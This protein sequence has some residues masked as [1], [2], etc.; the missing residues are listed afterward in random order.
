MDRLFRKKTSEKR[1]K[2]KKGK[3]E[4]PSKLGNAGIPDGNL[5]VAGP[6][7]SLDLDFRSSLMLPSLSQR[8]SVLMPSLSTAPEESLRALLASQRARSNGPALTMEE[9][10]ML[11]AELRGDE[12]GVDEREKKS[13]G[14]SSPGQISLFNHSSPF[15]TS[16]VSSPSLLTSSDDGGSA[17]PLH[18]ATNF[19][20]SPPPTSTSFSSFKTFG[21]GSSPEQP[22]ES[23]S[24]AKGMSY[25]I[26]G[27]INL[28]DGEYMRRAKKHASSKDLKASPSAKSEKTARENGAPSMISTEKANAYFKGHQ[29]RISHSPTRSEVTAT[30]TSSGPYGGPQSRP[31]PTVVTRQPEPNSPDS[32]SFPQR[33][34]RK[35]LLSNLS[36]AQ[37][38]RISMALEEI[39]GE[40]QRGSSLVRKDTLRKA[41][42]EEESRAD[43]EEVLASEDSQGALATLSE[44]EIDPSRRPDVLSEGESS[45][46]ATSSVF[47]FKT[48]PTNSTFTGSTIA[49]TTEPG[50]PSR[51]PPSPRS[52]NLRAVIDD[53][54][55]P[56]PKPIFTPTRTTPVK[57]HYSLSN[58]SSSSTP[59]QIPPNPAYVPGQPRPI[60]S[61]HHSVSSISSSR[62]GTPSGQSPLDALKNSSRSGTPRSQSPLDALRA[63]T[64]TTFSDVTSATPSP[65]QNYALDSAKTGSLMRSR[66]LQTSNPSRPVELDLVRRRAGTVVLGETVTPPRRLTSPHGARRGSENE[67]IA[68]EDEDVVEHEDNESTPE[69]RQV[70]SRHSVVVSSY[71]H[72]TATTVV[73]RA[74]VNEHLP[75]PGDHIERTVSA[76]GT[77]KT[78]EDTP[79]LS[80]RAS[81][82][83][84]D[85]DYAPES[86]DTQWIDV[87]GS[88][89]R[90]SLVI[91]NMEYAQD[92]PEG[93]LRKMSGLGAEELAILQGKLVAKAKS[94]REAMGLGDSPMIPATPNMPVSV[95]SAVQRSMSPAVMTPPTFSS[96]STSGSRAA[97]PHGT[98]G[99]STPPPHSADHILVKQP[100]PAVPS[101]PPPPAPASIASSRPLSLETKDALVASPAAPELTNNDL[102]TEKERDFRTRIA[103]A[104]ASLNR[105]PPEQ[106]VSLGRKN[107]KRGM[108]IVI[109]GPKLLSSTAKVPVVPLSPDHPHTIDP[110]MAK[111]LEK[112]SGSGSKMSQRWRKLMRKGPSIT[113]SEMFKQTHQESPAPQSAPIQAMRSQPPPSLAPSPV[114]ASLIQRSNSQA[115]GR[116]LEAPFALRE[117]SVPPPSAPPNLNMFRFPSDK[118][119][120]QNMEAKPSTEHAQ[121]LPT[122]PST[123]PPT[124]HGS[125]A[126]DSTVAKFLESGRQLGLSEE[127]LNEMLVHKGMVSRPSDIPKHFPQSHAAPEPSAASQQTLPAEP[128][129]AKER[130]GG[131]LRSLSKKARDLPNRV[132]T[133]E[134]R[135]ET[136]TPTP[137]AEP[138]Q[139][140]TVLRRT[141]IMPDGLVIVPSTPQKGGDA[142]PGS[143]N[144]SSLGRLPSHRQP[145]IRRKPVNLSKE[146]RELVSHS[147]PA[148][149][150]NFNF[151][152]VSSRGTPTKLEGQGLGFLDPGTALGGDSIKSRSNASGSLSGRSV[153]AMSHRSSTGGSVLDMYGDTG[154]GQEVLQ[155]SPD[156]AQKAGASLVAEQGPAQAVE[157]CEYADGRVI[158]SIVDAL[159]TSVTN[160]VDGE[161]YYFN[162][163]HSRT[164]SYASTSYASTRRDSVMTGF[165]SDVF[166]NDNRAG[167]MGGKIS[168][169]SNRQSYRKSLAKPRPPTDIYFT[170]SRD[171]AD[172]IDH[173]SRDL[174]ASHGRIGILPSDQSPNP[175][176]HTPFDHIYDQGQ[177][178]PSPSGNSQFE[179]A[180]SPAPP[181]R[182][183]SRAPTFRPPSSASALAAVGGMGPKRQLS[184]KLRQFGHSAQPSVA[185][186]MAEDAR[187][188][189][190]RSFASSV[191]GMGDR[192]VEDRLQDLIDRMSRAGAGR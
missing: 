32:P 4:A 184:L 12:G 187:S 156:G 80:P 61:H 174:E 118:A 96:I 62:A 15:L 57:H 52:H 153:S 151:D 81:S 50:S 27:G 110:A 14:L 130:K 177:T 86:D 58:A 78:Q 49:G 20:G 134:S 137:Q 30:P 73:S 79:N 8:F 87:L 167:P 24:K 93:M 127:Q 89:S 172:L 99:F 173:L 39:G 135:R 122:P 148:T 9:E 105:N 191:S 56:V 10:E 190:S 25:G 183:A 41:V 98:A 115:A 149:Q 157:I 88:R 65:L 95:H 179:D 108:G 182:R 162:R 55:P 146:D 59:T 161:D 44:L 119:E 60:R 144:S 166:T 169:L 107:T 51:L 159:R 70:S 132:R 158:W 123:A 18:S 75:I 74:L 67:D 91:E 125:Q 90:E 116:T 36:A 63:S 26:S 141:M 54:V 186:T 112:T 76:Q 150:P 129:F 189:S 85:S 104:T 192:P 23:F 29:T 22:S 13:P 102:E 68:E 131:L 1:P 37:A 34:Q 47:P 19:T 126:S 46:S 64:S 121:Q 92:D 117:D 143:P 147:P 33:K 97:S 133:P 188:P 136:G 152:N 45:H 53:D 16:S 145:S 2:S 94:E 124:A 84:L 40:L 103:A 71:D 111:S 139:D 160:S 21:V 6:A 163:N 168:A 180:P 77:I 109:S 120:S 11:I 17:S 31:L 175:A 7:P 5:R 170:S 35:S 82:D 171:V 43:T 106:G 69:L 140:R 185:S 28:R 138:N 72:D 38:K 42:V 165:G 181:P 176:E 155:E 128:L 164:S 100:L 66:S 154:T 114:P 3:S 83:T 113:N 48:S 178:P 142:V 101:R